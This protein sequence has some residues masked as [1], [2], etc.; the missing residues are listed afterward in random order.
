MADQEPRVSEEKLQKVIQNIQKEL[1]NSL[2][3]LANNVDGKHPLEHKR[4]HLEFGV[5]SPLYYKL[6]RHLIDW[7]TRSHHPQFSELA[8]TKYLDK[9]GKKYH[10]KLPLKHLGK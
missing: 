2:T 6:Q 9:T 8:L 5:V 4:F 7:G 10:D 3:S 1:N